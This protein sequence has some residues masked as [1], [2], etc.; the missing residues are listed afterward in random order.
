MRMVQTNR[1]TPSGL[2]K[3]LL[4]GWKPGLANSACRFAG[5]PRLQASLHLCSAIA[6]PVN[7]RASLATLCAHP[8]KT[9][10]NSGTY[11]HKELLVGN[12]QSYLV[13]LVP[14]GVAVGI[15]FQLCI[16]L[17][18]EIQVAVLRSFAQMLSLGLL[19]KFFIEE[20]I[21]WSLVGI[22]V[23]VFLAGSTAGEQSR[24]LPKS[25]VVAT[26]S[27]AFGTL[28]TVALMVFLRVLPSEPSSLIPVTGHILGNAMIMVGR[29]LKALQYEISQHTGQIEAALSLGATPYSSVQRHIQQAFVNGMAPMVDAVKVMGLVSLPGNMTGLLMGGAAPLEAIKIQIKLMNAVLGAAAISCLIATVLGWHMFFTSKSQLQE[30]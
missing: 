13:S 28:G 11:L 27:L 21:V 5:V 4:H 16:G 8:L 24:E 1:I 20:N 10:I 19:L 17:E 25:Q 6:I 12:W 14:V 7:A 9:V 29:T 18:F 3:R 22:I 15:S 2:A 26:A 30:G 23:M